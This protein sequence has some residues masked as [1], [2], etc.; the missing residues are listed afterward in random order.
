MDMNQTTVLPRAE[1]GLRHFM[2]MV[3][4][5]MSLGLFVTGACG[6]YMA[7]DPR[8]IV[9]LV[10]NPILFYGLM[11]GELGLVLFLSAAVARME[12][13]TAK[14]AFL[15]YAA[16]TGVSLST[17]YLAYTAQSIASTFFLTA[18]LFGVMAAYG[19]MTKTDLTTIGNILFMALI[20]IVLASVVNIWLHSAAI[21]WATT[22]IGILVFTGLT[23]YDSQKIKAIYR[24]G[25]DGSEEETKG[26]ILGALALYLDFINL[27]LSLL[28]ATGKRRD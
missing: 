24:P 19:Y 11:L 12:A 4:G 27:F 17:V 15:F 18:G 5:W 26:A 7:S 6:A 20:G 23:A 8:M 3:Y 22:Y 21:Q 2:H 10:H 28:R 13:S 25:S 16:L 1:T 14:F 9:N